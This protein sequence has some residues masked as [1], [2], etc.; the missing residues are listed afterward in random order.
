VE[1]AQDEDDLKIKSTSFK[2]I[3]EGFLSL[4][5]DQKIKHNILKLQMKYTKSRGYK[6][7]SL[8]LYR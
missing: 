4:K 1:V 3:I 5:P 7:E 2:N 6:L 8:D